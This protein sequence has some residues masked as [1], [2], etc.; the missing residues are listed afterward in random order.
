MF[1]VRKHMT[2]EMVMPFERFTALWT[3][4]FPF[5]TMGDHMFGQCA[6]ITEL[7]TTFHTDEWAFFRLFSATSRL[8]WLFRRISFVRID[9]GIMMKSR[10][11]G[12]RCR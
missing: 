11:V 9:I 3:D 4:E 6:L 7:F 12:I 1:P 2:I 10:I 8:C 5:I